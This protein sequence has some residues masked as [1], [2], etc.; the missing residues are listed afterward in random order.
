MSIHPAIALSYDALILGLDKAIEAGHVTKSIHPFSRY[1]LYNY[2]DACVYDKGWNEFTN[3]ARGL[4]VDAVDKRIVALPF[5]K[6]HNASEHNYVLPD[7][8]FDVYE[9]AD[10]SL[11][12]IAFYAGAW[13]VNTRGSFTSEQAC[14]AE[15]ML[16]HTGLDETLDKKVTYLV[17]I[18]YPLN[19]VVV[20]Y[21]DWAGLVF[22][23]AYHTSTGLELPVPHIPAGWN[24]DDM[25]LRARS[26]NTHHY[27]SIADIVKVCE[28]LPASQE[29][30]VVRFKSGF[31]V[32]IKGAE[33]LR[34]HKIKSCMSPLSIWETMRD[35]QGDVTA[36]IQLLPDEF[37]PEFISMRDTF[38]AKYQRR[39]E[40][41]LDYIKTNYKG[42]TNKEIGLIL[43]SN[44]ADQIPPLVR[45]L[46]FAI[47]KDSYQITAK[48]RGAIFDDFRPNANVI[49]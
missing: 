28:T 24:T 6:F 27:E 34:I 33:Y 14:F 2:T 41:V 26:V 13:R 32:K 20:G 4:V 5:P 9:K 35:G 23:G 37:Q 7:E 38:E 48:T 40:Y 3:V 30:F 19:R 18:I 11:G 25:A 8:P 46:I 16:S 31:R 45:K 17:E 36:Q 10:G 43:Q 49:V 42:M 39:V 22:L 44:R 15:H 29:G 21:G 12:I 47:I 1:V